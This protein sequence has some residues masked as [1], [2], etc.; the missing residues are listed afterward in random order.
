MEIATQYGFLFYLAL[1]FF[2][3]FMTL[4]QVGFAKGKDIYYAFIAPFSV[5]LVVFIL[6]R[7]VPVFFVAA[8]FIFGYFLL[9]YF[10]LKSKAE[11]ANGK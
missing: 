2:I 6:L 11:E 10:I 3:G 4:I 1:L 7:N 8:F 9:L 5:S